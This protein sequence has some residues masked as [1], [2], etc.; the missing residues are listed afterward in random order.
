MHQVHSGTRV[1]S[2]YYD[3]KSAELQKLFFLIKTLKAEAK[4]KKLILLT[5]PVK[6]DFERYRSEPSVPLKN[7][8]DSFSRAENFLYVDLL[9]TLAQ[10]EKDPDKLYFT[11]DGHW[12]GYANRLATEILVP[13][14]K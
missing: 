12:N 2:A 13:F 10:K 4:G 1:P 3:Y 11:C 6:P 7:S 9:T 14:L 8:L 5:L